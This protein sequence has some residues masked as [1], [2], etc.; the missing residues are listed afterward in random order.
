MTVRTAH[1]GASPYEVCAISVNQHCTICG[2]YGP[3][4]DDQPLGDPLRDSVTAKIYPLCG[5]KLEKIWGDDERC[6]AQMVLTSGSSPQNA[7]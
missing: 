4:K 3:P 7:K 5:C 2:S 1:A 6:E